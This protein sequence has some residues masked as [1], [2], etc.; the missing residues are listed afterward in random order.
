MIL[1]L[2]R[3]GLLRAAA[4]DLGLSHTTVSR[5]LA[6]TEQT[7]GKLFEQG[8]QGYQPNSL[9]DALIE[10]AEGM[11]SLTLAGA[12]YQRAADAELS[13]EV[14]LFLPEPIAQNLVLKELVEFAKAYPGIELKVETSSRFVDPDRSEADVVVRGAQDPPDHLVG[15]RLFPNFIT[16]YADRD[17]L[18]STPREELRWIAPA[19]D[20]LWPGWLQS[21]P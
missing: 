15:R 19:S 14:R 4:L 21:S 5:R 10:V 18:A 8:P 2:A 17:Y 20:G 16:Y 9:G 3:K 7:R 1:A 12:R 6:A 11:E 13:G